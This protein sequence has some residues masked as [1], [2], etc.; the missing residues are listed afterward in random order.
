MT[1]IDTSY[2]LFAD[3]FSCP[4]FLGMFN[5]S[6]E[7]LHNLYPKLECGPLNKY[8]S[9]VPSGRASDTIA[10]RDDIVLLLNNVLSD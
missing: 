4:N 8:W 1:K 3:M 9:M 2:D 5:L 10:Q 7:N 6:G